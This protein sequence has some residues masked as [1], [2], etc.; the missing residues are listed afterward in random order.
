MFSH[1]V[2]SPIFNRWHMLK[3]YCVQHMDPDIILHELHVQVHQHPFTESLGTS[4]CGMFLVSDKGAHRPQSREVELRIMQE[5]KETQEGNPRGSP[6]Q[7][8]QK[9]INKLEYDVG[10]WRWGQGRTKEVQLQRAWK[11][12]KGLQRRPLIEACG[13][14]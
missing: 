4:P 7:I 13:A 9:Y 5:P 1:N 6:N 2:Y 3:T 8:S 10:R 14:S 12:S 11:Q